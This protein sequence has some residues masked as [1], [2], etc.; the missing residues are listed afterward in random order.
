MIKKIL[1]FFTKNQLERLEIEAEDID[2]HLAK[3]IVAAEKTV[4][5]LQAALKNDDIEEKDDDTE[6]LKGE[7]EK[8]LQNLD[9]LKL[10]IE[11]IREIKTRK[12][13]LKGPDN[14]FL[15]DKIA[16]I[17]GMQDALSSLIS[18]LEEVPSDKE[19]EERSLDQIVKY[20]NELISALNNIKADDDTL[21][22]IYRKVMRA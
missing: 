19:Y 14:E 22:G 16:Q 2:G 8:I 4:K 12:N 21:L 17:R 7:F 15:N 9:T 6:E 3:M 20:L 5:D 1:S 11:K 18:I 13:L 10:D